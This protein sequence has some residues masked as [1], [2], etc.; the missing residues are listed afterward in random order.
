MT[1]RDVIARYRDL[2]DLS[3]DVTTTQMMYG[4]QDIGPG[5]LAILE[6]LCARLHAIAEPT[7]WLASVKEKLGSLRI[8]HRGD[9][10][11]IEAV[12]EVARAAA[13]VTC[14]LCGAAGEHREVGGW[15]AVRCPAC[16][17]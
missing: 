6:R 10:E 8:A 4:F 15:L 3:G 2:F 9:N 11:A 1:D 12:V 14:E 13:L 7:F 5:W 17:G 16:A